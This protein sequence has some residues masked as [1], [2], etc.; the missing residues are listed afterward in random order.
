MLL[1]AGGAYSLWLL[2]FFLPTGLDPVRSFVSEH[3]PV[4]QPYQQLFR[5]A[6]LV[7][8]ATYVSAAWLLR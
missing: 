6:D 2:E 8:G 1:A 5:T 7:A 3:Y 4:F